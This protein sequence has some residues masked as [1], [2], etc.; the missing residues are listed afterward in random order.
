[1]II[2]S[3]EEEE[4]TGGGDGVRGENGGGVRDGGDDGGGEVGNEVDERD[5][6]MDTSTCDSDEKKTGP[7]EEVVLIEHKN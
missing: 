3:D 4:E 6:G 1:V 7:S 2:D 5:E